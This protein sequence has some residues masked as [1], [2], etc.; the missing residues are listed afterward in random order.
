MSKKIQSFDESAEVVV[1]LS[2]GVDSCVLMYYLVLELG[3]RQVSGIFLNY[4]QS[5]AQVTLDCVRS[6]I[7]DLSSKQP[8]FECVLYEIESFP[9]HSL[10]NIDENLHSYEQVYDSKRS[11]EIKKETFISG[12]NSLIALAAMSRADVLSVGEAWM[13]VQIDRPEWAAVQSYLLAGPKDITPQWVDRVNLLGEVS[14]QNL[15]RL[16]TPFLDLR[17]DK[18]DVVSLGKDLG[19][20]FNLTYSCK[21]YPPCGSCQ[22]CL[23]RSKFIK[24]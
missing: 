17:W 10:S 19:V 4:N 14:F 1:V 22:Q 8:G 15:V 16:R 18:E 11:T 20:L 3:K 7:K 23:I 2:G 24:D 6:Q 9:W 13:S 5:N 12:R 21:Y